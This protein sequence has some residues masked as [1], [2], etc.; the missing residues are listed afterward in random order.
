M[1]VSISICLC[2]CLCTSVYAV[3]VDDR[4][5]DAIELVESS[6]DSTA[7][8]DNGKS[9]GSFQITKAYVDDVNRVYKKNYSYSDR[10]D[11]NKS[12]NMTRLYLTY[13]GNL[14]ER[15]TGQKATYEVLCR[16]HNGGPKGM[17]KNSTYSY[18]KKIERVLRCQQ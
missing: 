6:R 17:Y 12:R 3:V 2:L 18:W 5:L 9:V 1:R 10:Y 4:L 7:I 8:G 16:I 11:R 14:Y 13:Y 15:K